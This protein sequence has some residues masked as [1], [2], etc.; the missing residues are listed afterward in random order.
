MILGGAGSGKS[1]LA[2]ILARRLDIPV[3]HV[4]K[5]YWSPGWVARPRD[6]TDSLA[7]AAADGAAWVFDGNHLR[8][9]AYRAARAELIVFIDL[10]ASLR[11]WRSLRRVLRHRGET[12]PDMA[13]ACP[14]Q[15]PDRDFLRFILGYGADGRLRTLAFLDDW[16]G[17]VEVVHLETRGA[18]RAFLDDPRWRAIAPRPTPR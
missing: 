5:M 11:L 7:R 4:D 14:E 1:T 13:E 10:P 17:R 16:R 15:W 3:V 12:R 2:C 18:V 8:S 9:A 6:E